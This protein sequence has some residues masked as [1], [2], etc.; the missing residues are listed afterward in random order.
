MLLH[1]TVGVKLSK[2][3]DRN[4]LVGRILFPQGDIASEILKNGL[5]KLSTP[6]DMNFDSNYF[7]ELKTA[8]I[9]GQGKRAGVWEDYVE[10]TSQNQ[11][12]EINDFTGKVVEVHSGDCLTVEKDADFKL[13]KIYL[14]SI[15]APKFTQDVQES[16]GWESKEC[17][18]KLAIGKKVKVDVEFTRTIETKSGG[19]F[20]MNFGSV[21]LLQKNNKNVAAAQLEKGYARTNIHKDNMSKYLEDLLP[22]EKK[23]TEQK[24]HV[25]SKRDPP[26]KIFND[27]ISNPKQA[28]EYE[29]MLNKRADRKF[30]GVIEYCFSGQK[31]KVRLEGENC[32][33][34]LSLLG[35][36]TLSADKNQPALLEFAQDAQQFA[37]DNLLQRDVTVEI[38]SADKRG[39]FFGTVQ[40]PSK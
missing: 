24:L 27:L 12:S 30:Q 33:I 36:K 26:H 2:V 13:V 22:A 20:E 21:F 25:H 11:L 19:E 37:K 4:E 5:A 14:A 1:R 39:T 40:T 17:L 23:A 15:K 6:K 8:Q 38:F 29:Q 28:K 18:R 31:F 10:E 34:A 35:V 3:D 32:Y 9:I 16:Y 7:K